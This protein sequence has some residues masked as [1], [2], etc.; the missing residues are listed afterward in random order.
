MSKSDQSLVVVKV[1]YGYVQELQEMVNTVLYLTTEA[2]ISWFTISF[3]PI[4][5]L[6]IGEFSRASFL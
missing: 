2:K 5:S 4:C 3:S 1:F 6:K